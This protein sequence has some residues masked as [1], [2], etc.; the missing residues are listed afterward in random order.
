MDGGLCGHWPGTGYLRP[1]GQESLCA[2][3]EP[4]G[5]QGRAKAL[6]PTPDSRP[7]TLEP[8]HL[9]CFDPCECTTHS[10]TGIKLLR[11]KLTFTFRFKQIE[12]WSHLVLP[13]D[14]GHGCQVDTSVPRS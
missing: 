1:Q 4:R 14:R 9:F 10:E 6:G 8:R 5:A 3:R 7:S 11:L 2:E 13:G 12:N